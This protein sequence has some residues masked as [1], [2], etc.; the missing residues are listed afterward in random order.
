MPNPFL[1]WQGFLQS[2]ADLGVLRSLL[3]FLLS[4]P[5]SSAFSERL[6]S[7]AGFLHENR[8]NMTAQN[9]V[10]LTVIRDWLLQVGAE[11]RSAL[12]R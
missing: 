12:T 7:S 4:V 11:S 9:L 6:W 8:E 10:R 3:R 5:A 1:F 2:R